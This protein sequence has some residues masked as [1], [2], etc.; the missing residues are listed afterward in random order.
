MFIDYLDFTFCKA[1]VS[2]IFLV[3]SGEKIQIKLSQKT[4]WSKSL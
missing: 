4:A 2:I 1:S 3:D